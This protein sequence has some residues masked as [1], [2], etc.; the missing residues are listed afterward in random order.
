MGQALH[1]KLVLA[2]DIVDFSKQDNR[3]Q[4]K[5]REGVY[6]ILGNTL[7]ESIGINLDDLDHE[8]RGDG[9]FVLIPPE[10]D[11]SR[12]I[13][14]LIERT[15]AEIRQHNEMS[16]FRSQIRLRMVLHSIDVHRDERGWVSTDLNDAFRLLNCTAL[17]SALEE[18]PRCLLG[19]IVSPA[20][21]AVLK[22]GYGAIN[23]DDYWEVPVERTHMP[24]P[25]WIRLLGGSGTSHSSAQR[26]APESE[27]PEETRTRHAPTPQAPTRA[28][29]AQ[30]FHGPTTVDG[31][32]VGG[33]KTTTN[34]W[35]RG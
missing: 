21:H 6:T 28:S 5:M 29:A 30:I 12:L 19:V 15:Y 9:A 8:D 1:T 14:P 32:V 18:D 24:M 20:F 34:N 35:G 10:T 11:K 7:Q 16:S 4:Q 3:F 22:H 33:D 26:P 17:R 13:D 23:P 2:V 27:A 31:D 25:G